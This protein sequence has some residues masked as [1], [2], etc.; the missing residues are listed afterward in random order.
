MAFRFLSQGLEGSREPAPAAAARCCEAGAGEATRFV[1]GSEVF[2][3][4]ELVRNKLEIK[5]LSGTAWSL[6]V[7]NHVQIIHTAVL[8]APGEN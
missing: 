1:Q 8:L 4:A 6:R 7:C 2:R 3:S 5:L